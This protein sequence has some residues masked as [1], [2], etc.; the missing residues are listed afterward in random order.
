[1]QIGALLEAHDLC[2]RLLV[3]LPD[4]DPER[5][6]IHSELGDL[7]MSLQRFAQAEEGYTA[8]L[9]GLEVEGEDDALI[10]Q[11][12]LDLLGRLARA[13]ED[14]G[15]FSEARR[16]LEQAVALI[17]S[18]VSGIEPDL[19]D[20]GRIALALARVYHREG[21][22]EE[23]RTALA[24]GMQTLERH[25]RTGDLVEA[26]VLEGLLRMDVGELEAAAGI[27]SRAL[28]LA[29]TAGLTAGR[30][31][32]LHNL[33]I[34]EKRR[35]DL[36]AAVDYLKRALEL[37]ESLGDVARLG[38]GYNNLGQL[39]K[40]LGDSRRAL[41][42]YRRAAR[43]FER[44]G[45]R[46]GLVTVHYSQAELLRE[47][48]EYGRALEQLEAAESLANALGGG[49]REQA[50]QRTRLVRGEV[51]LA[52]GRLEEAQPL[53]EQCQREAEARGD[54]EATLAVEVGLAEI[55][56]AKG[57]TAEVER[58]CIELAK[59]VTPGHIDAPL[60]GLLT[61]LHHH[62]GH[63]YGAAYVEQCRARGHE[64]LG[65]ALLETSVARFPAQGAEG[66]RRSLE[67]A[68]RLLD[69]SGRGQL[70]ARARGLLQD[71]GAGID[72]R[73]ELLKGVLDVLQ[74]LG[75]RKQV[76]AHLVSLAARVLRA[77]RGLLL[78]R[79]TAGDLV[80][81][82]VLH[83]M[84]L[85][86]AQRVSGEIIRRVSVNREP[87]MVADALEEPSL[88]GSASIQ[89]LQ[90]RSVLG[91]LIDRD[92]QGMWILYL[93]HRQLAGVFSAESRPL[94]ERLS[95]LAAG[96]L[97]EIRFRETLLA[98]V[99]AP[100]HN[101]RR[102]GM[103]GRSQAIERVRDY[104]DNLGHLKLHNENLLFIG[105]SGTGKELVARAVHQV[106]RAGRDIP[107]IA[108]SCA[109]IPAELI[110]STLFGHRRGAFTGARE[111]RPGIFELASGGVLF[112]DEIGELPLNLQA[113]LLRVLEER[114]IS[115]IGE[116]ERPRALTL[117][118]VCATNRDLSREVEAGRFRRDLFHRLNQVFRLPPLR[119]RRED[120]LPL[121]RHFMAQVE[122][123]NSL[124][125]EEV[126]APEVL[127]WFHEH[128]WPGNIREL[129]NIVEAIPVRIK[130]RRRMMVELED[131]GVRSA[132]RS[133]HQPSLA[134]ELSFE[135]RET[136][137]DF[138]ERI[139]AGYIRRAMDQCDWDITAASARLG[140]T[141]QGLRK[142]LLKY[143]WM[144]EVER[145]RH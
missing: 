63:H 108:Q 139:E 113:S 41:Q 52:L 61:R 15:K 30:M 121:L 29:T 144:N 70:A 51:L 76:L 94:L 145:R 35:G 104:I 132:E 50:L 65:S 6:R 67:E 72:E 9:A 106:V 20:Y 90:I 13:L 24:R 34:L 128:P 38:A 114:T 5:T 43:T 46:A 95:Q 133:P 80:D 23:A 97:R 120:I 53:L 110:E 79:R 32:A 78:Y 103:V 19:P 116:P 75:D 12:R 74:N 16:R 25:Q 84:N 4:G 129:K 98:R 40:R 141:Y 138:T 59:R 134:P 142:R 14:Q 8:A 58:R 71:L 93:D 123:F 3:R 115:R 21:R 126:F 77:E 69:L 39:Q 105:E 88:I 122:D 44:V 81:F 56:L 111:D 18:G 119:E 64:V 49:F 42:S 85:G 102:Y 62:L 73:L 117:I 60:F 10:T 11:L 140:L 130:A 31:R 137:K 124:G 57:E 96:L 66:L 26:L 87:V 127:L 1:M 33:H 83:G 68:V 107:F 2:Q 82:T 54:R 125:P 99:E 48:G 45:D 131:L 27:F 143:E 101:G 112:L 89:D 109:D 22:L 92:E 17:E 86:E 91:L 55:W 136:L 118:V 28:E 36:H 47:R 100:E 135:T 7:N 37:A